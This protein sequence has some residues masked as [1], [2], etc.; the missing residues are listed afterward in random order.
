MVPNVTSDRVGRSV[1]AAAIFCAKIFVAWRLD[2][3]RNRSYR[4]TR[5]IV[6]SGAISGSRQRIIHPPFRSSKHPLPYVRFFV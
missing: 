2:I 5:L 3:A 4:K 6:P 1:D